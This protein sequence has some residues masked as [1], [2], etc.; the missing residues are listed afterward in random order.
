MARNNP[1]LLLL[2]AAGGALFTVVLLSL[3]TP[4]F[5]SSSSSSLEST[6]LSR[7]AS[8]PRLQNQSLGAWL[9]AGLQPTTARKGDAPQHD[10]TAGAA[11]ARSAALGGALQKVPQLPEHMQRQLDEHLARTLVD[12]TAGASAAKTLTQLEKA[13]RQFAEF[14]ALSAKAAGR[15]KLAL[16]RL[17]SGARALEASELARAAARAAAE[18][19]DEAVDTVATTAAPE[20]GPTLPAHVSQF[21]RTR[22]IQVHPGREPKRYKS[23]RKQIRALGYHNAQECIDVNPI[24]DGKAM[25][26]PCQTQR[27][28]FTTKS[29]IRVGNTCLD[30][31]TARDGT[32]VVYT[33]CDG[34]SSQQWDHTPATWH[35]MRSAPLR[36]R[37]A[38]GLCAEPEMRGQ[39]SHLVL[40]KCSGQCRQLFH[41]ES[42]WRLEAV[43]PNATREHRAQVDQAMRE[44]GPTVACW[45]L[46]HP[47]GHSKAR[48]IWRT[49]GQKCSYIVFV[50]SAHDEELP[51]VVLD[52]VGR[53]ESREV[54]TYKSRLA[55]LY[56]YETFLDKVDW[57]FKG[58]DDTYVVMSNMKVRRARRAA[59]ARAGGKE[60]G[61]RGKQAQAG[62]KQARAGAKQ[63]QAGRGKKV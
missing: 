47:G 24:F 58:D 27:L 5:L 53:T 12:K 54:L 30:A 51:T 42:D 20:P 57:H 1:A 48:G 19:S 32:L 41:V 13:R 10:D 26:T 38:P 45:I 44:R 14:Q 17:Q 16:T 6:S 52:L 63:A 11:G 25:V 18:L 7:H 59:G 49:W 2:A 39:Q 46:T 4:L 35:A 3:A 36:S 23:S 56:M 15:A 62:A 8:V 29:E 37:A 43:G 33:D 40:R 60:A 9:L 21:K 55:W 50:T 28:E 34:S 61:A 31:D 22:S